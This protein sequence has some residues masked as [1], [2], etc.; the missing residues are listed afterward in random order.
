MDDERRNDSLKI[1]NI[2]I[3]Y[4]NIVD[5][6]VLKLHYFSLYQENL[7]FYDLW[8]QL[9]K[10]IYK[11]AML[12]ML[13]YSTIKTMVLTTQKISNHIAKTLHVFFFLLFIQFFGKKKF[14]PLKG[15]VYRCLKRVLTT[16]AFC[17]SRL[18]ASD[19]ALSKLHWALQVT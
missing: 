5:M 15:G 2:Y 10:T 17:R 14:L 12:D 3:Y 6:F 9:E 13:S 11:P 8:E 18:Q 7:Q 4:I 19:D 16:S 1:I